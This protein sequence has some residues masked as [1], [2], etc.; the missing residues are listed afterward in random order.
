MSKIEKIGGLIEELTRKEKEKIMDED[1]VSKPCA[2]LELKDLYEHAGGVGLCAKVQAQMKLTLNEQGLGLRLSS[3][4][5]DPMKKTKSRVMKS[6]VKVVKHTFGSIDRHM[7]EFQRALATNAG[8]NEEV[9][10]VDWAMKDNR[11]ATSNVKNILKPSAFVVDLLT[12]D[13]DDGSVESP[14]AYIILRI[15]FKYSSVIFS[16]KTIGLGSVNFLQ[17]MECRSSGASKVKLLCI[18]FNLSHH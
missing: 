11:E 17:T 3:G 7:Q 9:D 4:M 18:F 10:E 5:Q 1:N 2:F 13:E 16:N 14:S 8:K 6:K 15:I 12:Q